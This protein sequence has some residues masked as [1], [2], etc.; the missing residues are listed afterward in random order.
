MVIKSK[1]RDGK[2]NVVS[3][4]MGMKEKIDVLCKK[5]YVFKYYPLHHYVHIRQAQIDPNIIGILDTIL[6]EW[7]F[8]HVYA[9]CNPKERQQFFMSIYGLQG[10]GKSFVALFILDYLAHILGKEVD[11]NHICFTKAELLERLEKAKSNTLWVLDEQTERHGVGSGRERTMMRNIE[12]VC[13]ARSLHFIFVSPTLRDHPHQFALQTYDRTFNH[14]FG[15][16]WGEV[17]RSVLYDADRNRLGVIYTGKPSEKLLKKYHKRKEENISAVLAGKQSLE[18]QLIGKAAKKVI[19][20]KRFQDFIKMCET[21]KSKFS[22][23]DIFLFVG[24]LFPDFTKGEKDLI[25]RK[26]R[27]ILLMEDDEN[28]KKI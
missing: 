19:K 18:F 27:Q 2:G 24:E 23:A 5:S 3:L 4:A 8:K 6:T 25:A 10:T 9:V 17:N 13:R 28:H 12:E 14:P 11:P 20:Y 26:V 7:F 22:I 15:N 16:K 1:G 21:K